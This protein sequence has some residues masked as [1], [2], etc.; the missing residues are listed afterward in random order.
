M[1]L[2][3]MDPVFTGDA[4][5]HSYQYHLCQTHTDAVLEVEAHKKTS[6]RRTLVCCVEFE[7]YRGGEALMS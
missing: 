2:H 7:H 4:I 1:K 3:L 6:E 5:V